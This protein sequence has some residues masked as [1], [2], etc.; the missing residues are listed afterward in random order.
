MGNILKGL[1]VKNLQ[2][3]LILVNVCTY[4]TGFDNTVWHKNFTV[5]K[6]YGSPLNHL[7]EN[8]LEF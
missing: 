8:L 4:V 3:F 6:F 7:E 1:I 5:V 2:G